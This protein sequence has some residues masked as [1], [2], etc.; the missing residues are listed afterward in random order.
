[1]SGVAE[2]CRDVTVVG[3]AGVAEVRQ[4]GGDLRTRQE[5]TGNKNKFINTVQ[6]EYLTYKIHLATEFTLQFKYWTSLVFRSWL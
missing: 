5:R 1:M 2:S 6:S 3:E 4:A